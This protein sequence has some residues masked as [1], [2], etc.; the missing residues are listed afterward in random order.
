MVRELFITVSP[1]TGDVTDDE[2]SDIE[3]CINLLKRILK[4][5]T[6]VDFNIWIEYCVNTNERAVGI[7]PDVVS[8]EV[9]RKLNGL[10]VR[11]GRAG[12]EV[13]ADF[14]AVEGGE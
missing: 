13:Y 6:G 2:W 4:K 1:D 14:P 5:A 11:C 3:R 12:M 7:E 10:V 8:D 9:A